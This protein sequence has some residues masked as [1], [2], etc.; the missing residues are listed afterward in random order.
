MAV[1]ILIERRI[2]KNREN[3]ALTLVTQL[4]AAASREPGYISG[5]TLRNYDDPEEYLVISEW[6]NTD[7]W[8]SWKSSKE[9]SEIQDKIDALLGEETSYKIY[10]YPE[11]RRIIWPRFWEGVLEKT[12]GHGD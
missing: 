1:K 12:T 10:Q 4:R 2:Q 11:K 6:Q 8:K 7:D 9:R 5:E 3:D